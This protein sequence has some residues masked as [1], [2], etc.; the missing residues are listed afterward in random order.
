MASRTLVLLIGAALALTAC[1]GNA[2]ADVELSARGEEGR[3]VMRA[4]GC[5]AC[6]GS[7]GDGGVGPSFVGLFGSSVPLDDGSSVIAD[8]QYLDES[9]TDPGAQIVEGY[10]V[11]MPENDL[12]DTEVEAIIDYIVELAEVEP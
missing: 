11:P 9:I 12:D 3:S 7:Q 5:A 2:A 10:R 6:H 8:R 1:G 4:S